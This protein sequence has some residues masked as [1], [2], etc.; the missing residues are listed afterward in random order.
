MAATMAQSGLRTCMFADSQLSDQ[1]Y[2][3]SSRVEIQR[4]AFEASVDADGAC[5]FYAKNI[6][7]PSNPSLCYSIA[8]NFS[9]NQINLLTLCWKNVD[10][11]QISAN[12]RV[13][14]SVF[15][16]KL[17]ARFWIA[18]MPPCT[19]STS[20]PGRSQPRQARRRPPPSAGCPRRQGFRL[21]R[22]ARHFVRSS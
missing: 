11:L 16:E 19:T 17:N 5:R 12:K 3:K 10:V 13:G 2:C 4:A 8:E 22:C 14:R 9:K 20:C 15:G 18:R 6:P 21:D 7:T 1:P